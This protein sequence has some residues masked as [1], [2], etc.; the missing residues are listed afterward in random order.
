MSKASARLSAKSDVSFMKHF[1]RYFFSHVLAFKISF[2]NLSLTPFATL[3]TIAAIGVCLSLPVGIFLIIKNVEHFSQGWDKDAAL[4]LY[5]DAKSTPKQINDILDKIK[6][7]PFV[8]KSNYITPEK[9][10]HEFQETSGLK[11]TLALLPQNPLPGVINI[12][13][14]TEKTTPDEILKMKEDLAKLPL[15]KQAQFDYEWVEKLNAALAFGKTLG[16]CLY[17]IISLGVILMV[18]NTIRLA[19]ARHHDEIEVL[20]LIGAT[21][22]FIRRPFLYRGILYG[23]LGGLIAALLI[24]LVNGQLEKQAQHFENLFQG[25]FLLE[26]LTFYDTVLLLVASASLGWLGAA[27]AFAQQHRLL[28]SEN[29]N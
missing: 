10:L 4:S 12:Q 14:K 24:T 13:I 23:G 3:M 16:N 7:Y 29:A 27:I 17:F 5:V 28:A 8:E 11:D 21:T 6:N 9:A 26:N 1:L 19:V 20:N 18:C 22:A 2:R 15:V 25:I